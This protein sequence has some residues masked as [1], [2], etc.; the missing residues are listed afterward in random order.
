MYLSENYLNSPL[1]AELGIATDSRGE[2]MIKEKELSESLE[3]YLKQGW[4]VAIHSQGDES[5]REVAKVIS[6]LKK[7]FPNTPLIRL[8]HSL[9]LPV[10][11]MPELASMNVSVSFHINHI[12]YYG[13]ALEDSIL[14][15][16]RTQSLLP[17][18]R[19]FELDMKPTLHADSPM[20]P[21]DAFS[22]MKTAILRKTSSGRVIGKEQGINIRQALRAMTANGTYQL[23]IEKQAGSL[24]KGK[25]ADFLILSENPYSVTPELLT[26]I[27]IKE[28]YVNGEMKFFNP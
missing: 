4:Q 20:F 9:L 16:K 5:N 18:K 2:A 22:L 25:W 10:E 21:A 14:G 3:K 24:E 15:K 6:D 7:A 27:K 1:S 11:I 26:A 19:A 13:D 28:V 23:G 12:Y 8:E 17:V